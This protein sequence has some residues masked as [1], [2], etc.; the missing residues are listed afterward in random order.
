MSEMSVI[1]KKSLIGV[2]RKQKEAV[3]CL[4][5]RK[6]GSH[7]IFKDTPAF[8]GQ[9]KLAGNLVVME[10]F[11]SSKKSTSTKKSVSMESSTSTKTELRGRV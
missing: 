10:K 4:G 2:G 6:I 7:R 5:L 8:R 1:L 9:V 11:V 3:R